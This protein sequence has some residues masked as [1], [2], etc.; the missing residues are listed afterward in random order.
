MQI[1]SMKYLI[2]PMK[3]VAI[4]LTQHCCAVASA[5]QPHG[6]RTER[7]SRHSCNAKAQQHSKV[8]V[9]EHQTVVE[10][11]R[12]AVANSPLIAQSHAHRRTSH[13]PAHRCVARQRRAKV[14]VHNVFPSKFLNQ[15]CTI[16][17]TLF[18]FQF[19]SFHVFRKLKT[20]VV[21][22]TTKKHTS[23]F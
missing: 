16:K 12:V 5:T 20:K 6:S 9:G 8:L 4:G 17:S 13:K 22:K 7:H 1:L 10:E 15:L 18:S 2:D 11:T 21:L 19:N 3:S 14:V 23:L